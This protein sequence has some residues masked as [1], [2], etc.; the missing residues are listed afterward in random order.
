MMHAMIGFGTLAVLVLAGLA[1]PL[2]ATSPRWFVPSVIGEILAGVLV[3]P[4]VFSAV[5]PTQATVSFLGEIGFAML[6]LTVGMHLPLRDRRLAGSLRSGAIA[7]GAVTA[8]SVP[9]GLLAAALTGS[10]H[11]AVYAVV[12]A[13][14][15][16]AVLLPAIQE[17]G[18]AGPL[19][20]RVIAQTTIAD[21]LTI[22]SVPIVLQ[23]ERVGHAVLGAALV[24][25]A[26]G[27]LFCAARAARPHRW[28]HLV[29]TRSKRRHW[30]L[31]LRMSL[32]ILFFLAWIAQRGGTSILVAGFGAGVTVALLGGPKRL[33]TQ[34]RG[35]ADG[36][37]IPLY[38]VVLGARLDL[39]GLFGNASLLALAVVLAVL[40]VLIRLLAAR[41]VKM[42]AAGALAATAQLGVPAA[43]ASLGLSAHVLSALT[44]TAIVASALISLAV[45]TVG[46]Q[47]LIKAE[48]RS[49]PAPRASA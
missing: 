38:F 18:V 36:F 12:L 30:A 13:S 3:G 49:A 27:L 24:A 20:L 48:A 6:M 31:D 43:V 42:P 21:V 15:S 33:S 34:V 29:R 23:P 7:A 46:V 26:A 47:L 16:A 45:S 11:A 10:S 32:L 41:L 37:F 25:L 17:A 40:N 28:V 5:D 8:L 2:L 9:A 4:R 19:V 35:I 22:V 39:G 14:G 44:A 1:G